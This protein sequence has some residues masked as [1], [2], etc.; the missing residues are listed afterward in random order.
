M[1]VPLKFRSSEL[2]GAREHWLLG[3][4]GRVVMGSVL[5]EKQLLVNLVA[6]GG[7]RRCQNWPPRKHGKLETG[8]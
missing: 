4:G 8:Q 7:Q 5:G 2:E 3:G 1:F 6:D